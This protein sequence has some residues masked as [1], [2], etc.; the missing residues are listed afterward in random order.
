VLRAEPGWQDVLERWQVRLIL[1][2]NGTPVVGQLGQNGWN[3]LYQ[4]EL[5][6][7]YGR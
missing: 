4:D 7:V 1:L 2:E 6:V 5:A 3:L